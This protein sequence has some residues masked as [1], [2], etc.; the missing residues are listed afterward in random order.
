MALAGAKAVAL[1][2]SLGITQASHQCATVHDLAPPTLRAEKLGARLR[3]RVQGY[4]AARPLHLPIILGTASGRPL[5]SP[6]KASAQS[7]TTQTSQSAE[8]HQ[9][10]ENSHH[11]N[12]IENGDIRTVRIELTPLTPENFAPFGQVCGPCVDGAEFGTDDAQ[13]ELEGGV[14]RYAVR[15]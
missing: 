3:N 8:S 6:P 15:Q 7:A 12:G 5:I 13:L 1:P 10:T 9:G 14:P 2:V 4:N 11:G